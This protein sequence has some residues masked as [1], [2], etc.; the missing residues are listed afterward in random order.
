MNKLLTPLSVG[1]FTTL[2]FGILIW[3]VL[4]V[5]K[6]LPAGTTA[7]THFG[8]FPDAT[9]LGPRTRVVMAG[10]N[11]GEI[12]E[13]VLFE[14][15]AKITMSVRSDAKLKVDAEIAKRQTSVLG[16]YFLELYPG[17]GP[18]D[19]PDGG[20]VKKVRE[21]A[22]MD[23]LMVK[24][25]GVTG[26]VDLVA[27]DIRMVTARLATIFGS[28][29]GAGKMRQVLHSAAEI[30]VKINSSVSTMSGKINR[31]LDNFGNVSS[32]LR[33]FT[34][35]TANSVKGILDKVDAVARNIRL[36]VERS[37]NSLQGNFGQVKETLD[38]AK[39]AVDSVNRSLAHIENVT[40]RVK[41][42]EGLVGQLTSKKSE[43]LLQK[44]EKL[45]DSGVSLL[46]KGEKLTD[47]ISDVVDDVGDTVRGLGDTLEPL[48][49]LQPLVDLRAETSVLS[50][51]IKTYIGLQLQTT[52]DKH[53][54]IELINDPRGKT[55]FSRSVTRSTSSR[56]DPVVAEETTLTEDKLKVTFQLAKKFYFTTWRFGVKE[57]SGGVGLDF[58]LPGRFDVNIDLFD[59]I[60][61]AR[62]R[63]KAWSTWQFYKP[64]Y[65]AG[66]V[67]DAF[68][69]ASRD[70]FV[71]LGLRFTDADLKSLLLI[72]PRTN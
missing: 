65:I 34:G 41:D 51:K 20:E 66:G 46:G 8:L 39:R 36:I 24:L 70:Y 35:D 26:T 38:G 23:T 18:D 56:T 49:R 55:S 48:T 44:G 13:I 6:G 27:K 63:L 59:F 37:G 9:G 67:D 47:K 29:E 40:G 1:I 61:D 7:R 62:P 14:G 60:G 52:L 43:P 72:A 50:G 22:G 33:G 68:N 15:R 12:K 71:S 4:K 32:R 53:Y 25:A 5:K 16:D 2:A 58:N 54:V 69:S 11:I 57:S 21:S 10:V 45:I 31:I 3:G 19:L 28:E 17:I 42:G 30:A 64:F